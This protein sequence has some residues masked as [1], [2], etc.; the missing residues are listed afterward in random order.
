MKIKHQPIC[1]WPVRIG[2]GS[3]KGA[4][5]P[6]SRTARSNSF[7]AQARGFTLIELLVVIAIIAILAAMLLPAL[8]AAKSKAQQATCVSNTKQLQLGWEMYSTDSQDFMVPNSPYRAG[9]NAN[10]SWCPNAGD[11]TAAMD[12]V[13][14]IGNTNTVPFAGTILAPY[15]G[16]QLGVYRCPADSVPSKNGFRVRSYS[17][18]AQVGN[19]YCH[20][21]SGT[22]P[23][24]P[25]DFNPGYKA[26]IKVSD[27]TGAPGPTDVIVFLEEHPDSLLNAVFDGYMQVDNKNGTFPDVPGSNH[28]WNCGLSFVDGH[29]E[30]HKWVTTVLKVPVTPD[31]P[32]PLSYI[33]AG[34][35]NADWVWYTT[36]CTGPL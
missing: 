28:K 24:G 11:L 14:R 26:Y 6:G 21:G 4:V 25:L 34:T 10:E 19:L 5:E 1:H 27:I 7:P 20:G 15:M 16:N 33:N 30:M 32:S 3:V 29:S 23:Q 13:N 9:G 36:H 8:A 2:Q 17:M 12:W 31:P 22:S 18:Q 35:L